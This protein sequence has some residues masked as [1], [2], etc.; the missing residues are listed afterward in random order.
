LE[1][2]SD[3][4][5]T[6]VMQNKMLHMHRKKSSFPRK[7]CCNDFQHEVNYNHKT[8]NVGTSLVFFMQKYNVF[9]WVKTL[10]KTVHNTPECRRE[11]WT[12]VL[13]HV[14]TILTQW[15]PF[16]LLRATFSSPISQSPCQTTQA[17]TF[18]SQKSSNITFPNT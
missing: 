17:H 5:I 18:Y 11:R 15:S 6:T 14:G 3:N 16:M 8:S 12:V 10:R 7:L 1:T 13:A 2:P 9:V 4:I